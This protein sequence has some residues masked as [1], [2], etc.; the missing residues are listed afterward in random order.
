MASAVPTRRDPGRDARTERRLS[1]A[2]PDG[3]N[4]KEAVAAM[5]T[6][7]GGAKPERHRFRN[8]FGRTVRI[9]FGIAFLVIAA[10]VI[11]PYMFNTISTDAVIN[12]RVISLFTPIRGRVGDELPESGLEIL[13][14][15]LVAIVRDRRVDRLELDRIGTELASVD[16]RISAQKQVLVDFEAIEETLET[17]RSRFQHAAEALTTYRIAE[18]RAILGATISESKRLDKVLSRQSRLREKGIVS[19]AGIEAAAS[20]ADR[21]RQG[22]AQRRA[23]IRRLS[24]EL[25]AIQQGIFADASHNDVPY[26]QQ[27]QDEIALRKVEVRARIR[28][29]RIRAEQLRAVFA[30]EHRRYLRRSVAEIRAPID[31]VMWRNFVHRGAT[32]APNDRIAALID[33]SNLIVNVALDETYFEDIHA[34]D[35]ATVMLIGSNETLVAR[36]VA[37]RAMGASQQDDLLAAR[38]PPLKDDQF[39]ATLS[40][41]GADLGERTNNFCHVGRNAEVRFEHKHGAW[42]HLRN[43]L[44]RDQIPEPDTGAP[45]PAAETVASGSPEPG[46]EGSPVGTAGPGS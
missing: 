39:L 27:R 35:T 29:M 24:M 34:G 10:M 12:A 25:R 45:R 44:F 8:G 15:D 2:T 33:C 3:S 23:E 17:N 20:A 5:D 22:V 46:E 18:A 13:A 16:E 38:L 41:N 43:I 37:L 19:Q 21:A 14:G 31:G 6:R 30:T 9:L 1:V 42:A 7:S 11:S 28:E 32:V 40:I 4:S 36:V 26:S